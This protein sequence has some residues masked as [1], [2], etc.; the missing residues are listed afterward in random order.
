MRFDDVEEHFGDQVDLTWK[1]F[2]LRPEPKESTV[3][4]FTK[5]TESWANPA[6]VEPRAVFN[7]WSGEHA[8]PS[9]SMPAQIAWKIVGANWPE[10]EKLLHHRLLKAYFT[11]NLT[12][13]DWDVL[14]DL[15]QQVDVN[16]ED[17]LAIASEQRQQIAQLV[18]DDHNEAVEQ[19]I[20]AVP[21]LLINHALPVPGAQDLDSYLLWIQ[22]IIDRRAEAAT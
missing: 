3:E 9:S 13:S 1:S 6:A 20:G 5:Y 15:V 4:K 16:R 22:K 12:I 8:P 19:G 18:I 14:A 21:T 2:L 7:Q 17:F 11:E 10:A